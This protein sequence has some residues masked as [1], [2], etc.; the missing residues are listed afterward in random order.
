MLF[1][2]P[3]NACGGGERKGKV[4]KTLDFTMHQAKKKARHKGR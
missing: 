2:K 4:M 1:W 3:G